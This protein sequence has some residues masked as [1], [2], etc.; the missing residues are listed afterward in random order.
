MP[1]VTSTRR[2]ADTG[3]TQNIAS[4]PPMNFVS[5]SNIGRPDAYVGTMTVGFEKCGRYPRGLKIRAASA[6]GAR[7]TNGC[8]ISRFPFSHNSAWLT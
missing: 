6:N 7:S 5:A 1:Y 3:T 4:C 2:P 8:S